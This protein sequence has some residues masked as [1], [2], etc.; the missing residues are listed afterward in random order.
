V[1]KR[2]PSA[3]FALALSLVWGALPIPLAAFLRRRNRKPVAKKE[4]VQ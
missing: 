1:V 4:D 3:S 2:T